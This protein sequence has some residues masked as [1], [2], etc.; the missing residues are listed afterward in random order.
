MFRQALA[1]EQQKKAQAEQEFAMQQKLRE[2]Q[3]KESQLGQKAQQQEMEI[4]K[5]R[6]EQLNAQYQKPIRDWATMLGIDTTGMSD[7]LLNSAVGEYPDLAS[8]LSALAADKYN[9]DKKMYRVGLISQA[10]S[11]Q[12]AKLMAK[13]TL[14]QVSDEEAGR[15]WEDAHMTPEYMTGLIEDAIQIQT[16]LLPQ[17]SKR[18]RE[19]TSL[20]AQLAVEQDVEKRKKLQAQ[21]DADTKSLQTIP[22]IFIGQFVDSPYYDTLK[23]VMD[24]VIFD[25][26]TL[27]MYPELKADLDLRY[28]KYMLANMGGGSVSG[29]PSGRRHT[30]TERAVT[31]AITGKGK[32]NKGDTSAGSYGAAKLAWKKQ[33]GSIAGFGDPAAYK[34]GGGYGVYNPMNAA[35]VEQSGSAS[36]ADLLQSI[37]SNIQ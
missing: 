7:E 8:Q 10:N 25:T 3:L 26:D 1:E 5:Q 37:L 31:E 30:N 6:Q 27:A 9:P 24:D 20:K 33:T 23:S 15:L 4:Q 34:A 16:A 11:K 36:D 29:R 13:E 21:I 18:A 12:A 19:L 17:L 2:E 32:F 22:D 28:Q 35:P 14:G